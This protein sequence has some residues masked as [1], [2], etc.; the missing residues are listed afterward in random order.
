[1]KKCI[2][3]LAAGGLSLMMSHTVAADVISLGEFNTDGDVESF[4]RANIPT[5]DTASGTLNGVVS[6]GSDDPQLFRTFTTS[7]GA[8]TPAA[9][10]TFTTLEFRVQEIDDLTG[11]PIAVFD[12]TG[13][14]FIAN[15][16]ILA[17]GT[18]N[19]TDFT[20]VA[21]GNNFFTVTADI[22]ALGS[23]PIN[24]IRLDPVGGA[25]TRSNSFAVDFIRVNTVPEPA[26][27]AL[28][29][30]GTL[31]MLGRRRK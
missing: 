8:I 1:M 28:L 25:A 11:T 5:L 10:D 4:T 27:M 30:L 7:G 23:T 3:L 16:T 9:G 15:G 18:A 2:A 6:S 12:P 24:S 13:L 17:N 21:S 20:A 31:C 14:I 22:S 19:P 26:S 29:G